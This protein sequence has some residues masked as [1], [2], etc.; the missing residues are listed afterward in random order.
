MV[1]HTSAQNPS[2]PRVD[3]LVALTREASGDGVVADML[4][5]PKDAEGMCAV[6]YHR[7]AVL[8]AHTLHFVHVAQFAAHV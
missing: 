5:S 7:D 3:G 1:E 8:V 6:L 4:V 2:L